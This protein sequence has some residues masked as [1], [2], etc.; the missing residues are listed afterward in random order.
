MT[1]TSLSLPRKKATFSHK[2]IAY[3]FFIMISISLFLVLAMNYLKIDKENIKLAQQ[4]S[5]MSSTRPVSA[6]SD[7]AKASVIQQSL[8]P[9]AQAEVAALLEKLQSIAL[10]PSDEAPNLASVI[11]ISKLNEETFFRNAELDDKLFVYSNAHIAVLYRPSIG[12][13]VNMAQLLDQSTGGGGANSKPQVKGVT[14]QATSGAQLQAKLAVYYATDSSRLRA[15]VGKV[16]S[17]MPNI[18]VSFEALTRG[19]GYTGTT[20]ID[21]K[22]GHDAIVSALITNLGGK[23]GSLPEEEDRPDADI[24]AIVGE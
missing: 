9:V 4:I 23:K 16:L 15:K 17:N 5:K 6:I 7:P 12:K 8:L 3:S 20:V 14:K 10:V 22:G 19:T 21:L 24:L 1:Y 18:E 13:I 11:D 2:T